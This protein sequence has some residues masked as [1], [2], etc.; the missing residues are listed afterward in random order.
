[1][2]VNA[3]FPENRR[4]PFIVVTMGLEEAKNL[5]GIACCLE[6][7]APQAKAMYAF[8]ALLL[9]AIKKIEDGK[10]EL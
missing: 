4:T 7:E 1:M 10:G 3:I 5:Q 8:E 6:A 9:P 2:R